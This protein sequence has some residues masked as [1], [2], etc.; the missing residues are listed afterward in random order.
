MTA[1][2]GWKELQAGYVELVTKFGQGWERG[3]PDEIAELFVEDGV[4]SPS[5]FDSPLRGRSAI[6]EYWKDIPREQAEIAFRFGEV[7]VAGPWFATE[8][9]CT[10]RRRRTGQRID[11]RG[12]LFCETVEGKIAEMRM[13]WHRVAR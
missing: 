12:A 2:V 1:S 11:V 10:F 7:F 4:F 9:K 3:N 13:Y 6:L 5:P 8:I